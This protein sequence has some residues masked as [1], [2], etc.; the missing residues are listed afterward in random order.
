MKQLEMEKADRITKDLR[1]QELED[2]V[3]LYER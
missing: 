2:T 3:V 1:L